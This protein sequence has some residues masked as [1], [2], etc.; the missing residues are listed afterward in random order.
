MLAAMAA[1]VLQG[2]LVPVAQAMAAL[3][4]VSQPAAV[5]NGHIHTHGSLLHSH[6]G[7]AGHVH[8]VAD[9]D[10]DDT[11]GLGKI[12]YS[13]CCITSAVVA[14]SGSDA[15]WLEV[16]SVLTGAVPDRLNGIEPAAPKPPPRPPSIT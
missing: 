6:G 12:F 14:T 3:G 13:T 4:V 11:A 2:A 8:G 10:D 5:V 15:V 7:G 1:F 9:H 16:V